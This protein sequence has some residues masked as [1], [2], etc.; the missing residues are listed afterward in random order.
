MIRLG[1]AVPHKLSHLL[2]ATLHSVLEGPGFTDAAVRR[3]VASGQPPPDL[4]VLVSKIHDRAYAVTDDE[5]DA[6]RT[7]YSE[8]Q[9]FEL[10]VA[11]AVGAAAARLKAAL[12]ALDNV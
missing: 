12:T 8:V 5:V 3:L 4:T 10:M 9:L 7:R 6:L 1:G 2:D 11:A